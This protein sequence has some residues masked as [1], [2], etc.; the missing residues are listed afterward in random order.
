M[1]VIQQLAGAVLV[2]S[3]MAIS[4]LANAES[5]SPRIV[6]GLLDDQPYT[7]VAVITGS[8]PEAASTWCSG[9]LIGCQTVLTAAHCVQDFPASSTFVY[10]Q[11]AGITAVDSI[12]A[13]P[14]FNF[15]VGDVAI[16][17]LKDPVEGI[18]PALINDIQMVFPGT[19]GTIAGFG[20]TGGNS[21]DYGIKRHGSVE[22]R[23]CIPAGISNMTSV[24]WAFVEPQGNPGENS[25][26]CNADSGGPLY[27]DIGGTEVVAG[28]TSGGS[29]GS[30]LPID[31]SY[32]ANVFNYSGWIATT[33]GPDIDN[34]SCGVLPVVGGGSAS[35][36]YILDDVTS[37]GNNNDNHTI[38]VPAGTGLLRVAM[39][40]L[41]D[42][43]DFDM[44]VAGPPGD[45]ATCT[46]NGG[47][48]Y[49][50]CEFSDPAA[51]PWMVSI[52]RVSGGG[53]YQLVTTQFP[54]AGGPP[55]TDGDGV[56]DSIDNCPDIA[57]ADQADVDGD[58]VGDVC[59][60]PPGCQ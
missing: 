7:T 42:G 44:S 16:L 3:A 9:T 50:A 40:G 11:H 30:C 35:V 10:L 56:P 23:S 31:R 1:A 46:R 52:T 43:S 27:V 2:I 32:D 20:R 22:T 45:A 4:P 48:Q 53:I 55:D 33:A 34:T 54:D 19:A 25:N 47:G 59:D 17:H 41:D 49:A 12:T 8:D 24:C 28:I 39:N 21:S 5:R 14:N 36:A 58:G 15:P 38:D 6:N 13:H 60:L 18:T 26:T 51:G 37:P 57:N 29:N